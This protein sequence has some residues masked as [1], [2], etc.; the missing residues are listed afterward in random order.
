LRRDILGHWAKVGAAAG[1]LGWMLVCIIDLTVLP[2]ADGIVIGP[3][4]LFTNA[5]E[6]LVA[7]LMGSTLL[8][9]VAGGLI[10]LARP[11]FVAIF[12]SPD[13]FERECGLPPPRSQTDPPARPRTRRGPS[14]K[15]VCFLLLF[16]AA[17]CTAALWA[18]GDFKEYSREPGQD[19]V[20]V[21][22]PSPQRRLVQVAVVGTVFAALCTA[23]YIL[24]RRLLPDKDML[25][26]FLITAFGFTLVTYRYYDGFPPLLPANSETRSVSVEPR[27]FERL[28][29]SSAGGLWFACITVVVASAYRTV[30]D[31]AA[32]GG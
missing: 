27:G 10:E 1:F 13:Q 19:G 21:T 3:R 2:V 15:S 23:A 22:K 18:Q 7:L 30:R 8:A 31:E 14:V 24:T 25:R 11:I 9:M 17:S 6:A 4:P 32:R 26:L 28:F 20:R 29:L 16:L 12:S 5:A